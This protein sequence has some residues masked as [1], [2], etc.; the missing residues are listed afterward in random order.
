MVLDNVQ[1]SQGNLMVLMKL[2]SLNSINPTKFFNQKAQDFLLQKLLCCLKEKI[3]VQDDDG[4]FGVSDGEQV[5]QWLEDS[6]V[7]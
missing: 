2:Q 7:D 5:H 4:N 1:S 6:S 3:D